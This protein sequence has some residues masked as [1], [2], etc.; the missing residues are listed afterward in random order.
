MLFDRLEPLRIELPLLVIVIAVIITAVGVVY[1][2]HLGRIEFVALQK[3]EQRRDHLNEE[4]GRLLLEESTWASPARIK[5]QAERR[6]EMIAPTTD[7]TV[8]IKP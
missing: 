8:V 7:M 2:K 1:S 4:W 5:Q 6:L 3:L